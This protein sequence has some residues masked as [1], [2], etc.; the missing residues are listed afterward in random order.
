[1]SK[2]FLF[3]LSINYLKK[4]TDDLLDFVLGIFSMVEVLE[5]VTTHRLHSIH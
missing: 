1:M 5:V 4:F 2:L 3:N